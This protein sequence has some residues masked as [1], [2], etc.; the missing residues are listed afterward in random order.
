[1]LVKVGG[2][3]R[4][5]VCLLHT[6]MSG[7][8]RPRQ[9][10]LRRKMKRK[11]RS[12]KYGY[13][14]ELLSRSQRWVVVYL[15]DCFNTARARYKANVD[16]FSPYNLWFKGKVVDYSTVDGRHLIQYTADGK[17]WQSW[18]DVYA[19]EKAG[20]FVLLAARFVTLYPHDDN[21]DLNAAIHY[22]ETCA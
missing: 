13:G 3:L 6:V 10:S 12:A 18:H 16:T 8:L 22:E 5:L 1:M 20:D 2:S 4:L 15:Y 9:C 21:E 7:V 14:R 11:R 19:E 17:Q